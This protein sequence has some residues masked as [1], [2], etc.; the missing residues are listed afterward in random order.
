[1]CNVHLLQCA[2]K[3]VPFSAGEL[4]RVFLS[5][6]EMKKLEEVV[7]CGPQDLPNMMKEVMLLED[8]HMDSLPHGKILLECSM[9]HSCY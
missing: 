8:H 2:L 9:C 7:L 6:K 4:P 1:M 3:V 5:D